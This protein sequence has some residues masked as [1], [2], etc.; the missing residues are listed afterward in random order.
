MIQGRGEWKPLLFIP[1]DL[2][3]T[4]IACYVRVKCKLGESNLFLRA[5]RAHPT[6]WPV[7]FYENYMPCDLFFTKIAW[8]VWVKRKLGESNPFW[9]A[10]RAHPPL[11]PAFTN[12]ACC[13]RVKCKLGICNL[14][15][16]A[17]RA[18]PFCYLFFNENRMAQKT[19]NKGL[20]Y[21]ARVI[22][23]TF[24]YIHV[25]LQTFIFKCMIMHNLVI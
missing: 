6:L 8:R 13:V 22:L 1:C 17:K 25:K 24:R 20:F 18:H 11:W 9:R 16:R 4:K 10:K 7:F 12:I 15:L 23:Y 5:K 19:L 3:F 2:L 21:L 14:F